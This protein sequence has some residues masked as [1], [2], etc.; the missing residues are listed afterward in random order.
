MTDQP[1]YYDARADWSLI[2]GHMHDGVRLYVMRGVPPGSFLTA[3]LEND[4]MGAFSKADSANTASMRGWAQFIY[5]HTPSGS[6]GSREKV[7]AWLDRGGI[8]GR[9]DQVPAGGMA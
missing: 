9:G 4:L 8:V 5:M 2:P 7:H 1:D 6:H 3:V